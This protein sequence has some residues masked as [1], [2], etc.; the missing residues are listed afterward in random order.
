MP[1]MFDVWARLLHKV[2]GSVLWLIEANAT[3][4]DN[5]RREAAARRVVARLVFAPRVRPEEHLAR[6]AL[7]DLFF[8]TLLIT[9]TLRPAMRCGRGCRW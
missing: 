3:A 2:E 5:L 1:G 8:D 9:P 6:H 7:A 4:S